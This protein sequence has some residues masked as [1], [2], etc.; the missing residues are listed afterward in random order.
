MTEKEQDSLEEG[1]PWQRRGRAY[2]R[3]PG[4]PALGPR[5]VVRLRPDARTPVF[6]TA[7][8]PL[9]AFLSPE[10]RSQQLSAGLI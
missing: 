1:P 3:L 10:P 2:S 4:R 9:C 8:P 5:C 6:V 7:E